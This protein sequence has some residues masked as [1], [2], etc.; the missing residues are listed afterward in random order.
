M[1]RGRNTRHIE[2][3]NKNVLKS[4]EKNDCEGWL[5]GEDWVKRKRLGIL[6]VEWSSCD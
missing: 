4:C 1:C 5:T 6:L 2:N 3:L